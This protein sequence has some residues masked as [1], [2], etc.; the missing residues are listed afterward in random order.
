VNILHTVFEVEG[1]PTGWAA[2]VNRA[3]KV[4]VMTEWNRQ[5]F[6]RS[7]VQPEKLHVLQ[8]PVDAGRYQPGRKRDSGLPFR[9]L[10]VMD[11]QLRK[12]HDL[13]LPAFAR[14]FRHGEAELWIK[15]MPH[16]ELSRDQIQAHCEAVVGSISKDA[17]PTVLVID[18]VLSTEA[19]HDLYRQTDGFVLASRGEGWGRP[20]HEAMLMELPVV[21]SHGS[22]LSTLVPDETVGYPVRCTLTPVSEEAAREVPAFRGQLWHEPEVD[23]LMV[24]L[25]EVAW[26][27]EESQA[28][29]ARGR[30]HITRLCDPLRVRKHLH[31]LVDQLA[32]GRVAI[33]P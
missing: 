13:L 12:G 31:H 3:D 18:D 8:P 11:W 19:L 20:V 30:E 32:R 5:V 27:R 33:T 25:R 10:S 29:G 4:L 26:N 7:G 14:A 15:V 6:A 23:H 17:P 28:R 2:A 24:R 16:K 21:V 1:L 22:A 9:W